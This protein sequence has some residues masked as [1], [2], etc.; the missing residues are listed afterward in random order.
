MNYLYRDS[1]KRPTPQQLEELEKKR[2]EEDAKA[3]TNYRDGLSID[4]E[5]FHKNDRRTEELHLLLSEKYMIYK[6]YA[7]RTMLNPQHIGK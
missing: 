5:I 2:L 3:A 1:K 7:Q 6:D 4:R